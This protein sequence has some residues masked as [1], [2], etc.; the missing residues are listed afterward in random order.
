[1]KPSMQPLLSRAALALL[2]LWVKASVVF[3]RPDRWV[4][5]FVETAHPLRDVG[6]G[7]V[8]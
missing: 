2:S 7:A 4:N 6:V 3:E 1:M 5:L 8:P